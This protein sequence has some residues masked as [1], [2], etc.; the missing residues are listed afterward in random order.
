[1]FDLTNLQ[2]HSVSLTANPIEDVTAS[3]SWHGLWLDKHIDQSA[4]DTITLNNVNGNA[5]T[6]DVIEAG[7]KGVGS[8]FDIDATYD[9]TE[10][11]QLGLNVGVFKPGELFRTNRNA[12]QVIANV[13]VAF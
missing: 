13:N 10:D 1:M 12:K 11:V 6:P 7:R 5:A 9:Y 2:I 3:V 8:E 4:G